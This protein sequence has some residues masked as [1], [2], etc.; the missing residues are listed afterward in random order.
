MNNGVC[1]LCDCNAAPKHCT[2]PGHEMKYLPLTIPYLGRQRRH[3][4]S[5]I[6]GRHA[7]YIRIISGLVGDGARHEILCHRVQVRA[8]PRIQ[9]RHK[10]CGD[11]GQEV[12][13]C[14]IVMCDDSV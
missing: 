4:N 3:A 10:R 13:V 6:H 1:P 14:A 11:D 5:E 2:H 7:L 12:A 8:C 9:R